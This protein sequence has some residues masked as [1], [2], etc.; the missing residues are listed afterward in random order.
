MEN[1]IKMDEREKVKEIIKDLKNCSNSELQYALKFLS[2]DYDRTKD[3]LIQL[4]K[5]LDGV[6]IIYNKILKEN[7]TRNVK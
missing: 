5:H 2:A 3:A 6:E 7:E 1:I 4:T